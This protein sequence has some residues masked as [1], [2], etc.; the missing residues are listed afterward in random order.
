MGPAV[1]GGNRRLPCG[2]WRDDV[3]GIAVCSGVGRVRSTPYV[4]SAALCA[5]EVVNMAEHGS[6]GGPR[7]AQLED[8]C[9][10][11]AAY[12]RAQLKKE[13]L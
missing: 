5:A 7:L 2:R 9:R 3:A 10:V 8:D 11:W 6:Y 13:K 1:A 4:L 12:Q